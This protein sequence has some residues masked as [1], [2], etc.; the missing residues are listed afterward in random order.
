M[1]MTTNETLHSMQQVSEIDAFD[2]RMVR[3]DRLISEFDLADYLPEGPLVIGSHTQLITNVE[4]MSPQMQERFLSAWESYELGYE[5]TK[6]VYIMADTIY[7]I[8]SAVPRQNRD[9]VLANLMSIIPTRDMVPVTDDDEEDGPG[10]IAFAMSVFKTVGGYEKVDMFTESQIEAYRNAAYMLFG[11]SPDPVTD[12]IENMGLHYG[13]KT[14]EVYSEKRF[15]RE[16]QRELLPSTEFINALL[17]KKLLPSM[18]ESVIRL[19]TLDAET[20][21][22]VVSAGVN[23]E[24]V[25]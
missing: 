3:L 5:D 2:D 25:L 14:I 13:D 10:A 1:D 16:A 7:G 19:G 6:G 12:D 20:V 15:A 23:H 4:S 9:T 24:G 21:Q 17:G 11:I 18:R 8:E 22:R